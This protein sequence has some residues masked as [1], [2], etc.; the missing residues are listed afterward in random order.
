MAYKYKYLVLENDDKLPSDVDIMITN[1]S[2]PHE[3]L[4]ICNASIQDSDLFL[5]AFSECERLLFKPTQITYSQYNLMLMIMYKLW[6]AGTL[7][8]KEVHIY[9]KDH[10]EAERQLSLLWSDKRKFLDCV[11]QQVEI[12]TVN[13]QN[14]TKVNL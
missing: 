3:R 12:F 11:L 6:S 13:P 9:S 1:I 2:D 8:I 4:I 14:K 7:G 10:N 5:S